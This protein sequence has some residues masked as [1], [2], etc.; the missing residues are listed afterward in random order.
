M[1]NSK[2]LWARVESEKNNDDKRPRTKLGMV[3]MCECAVD[4]VQNINILYSGIYTT[5]IYAPNKYENW[6][7]VA[8]QHFTLYTYVHVHDCWCCCWCTCTIALQSVHKLYEWEN[9]WT[10]RSDAA[11]FQIAGKKTRCEVRLSSLHHHQ[12][13]LHFRFYSLFSFCYRWH[14]Q[15]Q[16]GD[17]DVMWL[18]I[19]SD[20][21]IH[22][23]YLHCKSAVH[24]MTMMLLMTVRETFASQWIC[25]CISMW[26]LSV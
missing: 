18:Y 20:Y 12:H 9:F 17:S 14:H 6:D 24:C 15:A 5:C 23:D 10:Q 19:S 11:M 13:H 16:I 4:F 2:Y 25:V 22:C 21:F 3:R 26:C 1:N 8:D 7:P